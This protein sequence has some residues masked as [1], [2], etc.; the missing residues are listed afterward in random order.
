MQIVRGWSRAFAGCVLWGMLCS[1][2]VW[3]DPPQ[4]HDPAKDLQVRKSL[5]E[6]QQIVGSWRGTGQPVR[7][8]NRGAWRETAEWVWDLK[9]H[10]PALTLKI[11]DGKLLRGGSLTVDPQTSEFLFR[12]E[13]PERP[14]QTFRGKRQEHQLVL[15]SKEGEQEQQLTFTLL[16]DKR[17]LIRLEQRP[18]SAGTFRQVAEIGYTRAGTRLAIEG[19]SNRECVVTGGEGTLRVSYKGKSYW[20]CCTGCKTAFD[21]DPETILKEYAARV[22]KRNQ[23]K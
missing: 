14:S 6:F 5:E 22:A 21:E 3:G 13:F 12:A 4:A 9:Q 2:S 19:V 11:T 23:D 17:S 18:T 1:V 8:S 20:V 10:P 7:N 16:N 15:I